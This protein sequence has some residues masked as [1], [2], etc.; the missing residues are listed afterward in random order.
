MLMQPEPYL[1]STRIGRFSDDAKVHGEN[2]RVGDSF[3]NN[4]DMIRLSAPILATR[5]DESYQCPS[6]GESR[7][8][9]RRRI[10]FKIN[11]NLSEKSD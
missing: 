9:C 1:Y 10:R 5:G 6:I 8:K 3:N 11:K 7:K 2:Y 4:H